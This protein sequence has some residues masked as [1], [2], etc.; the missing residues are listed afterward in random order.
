MRIITQQNIVDLQRY[1]T[2]AG[3][4]VAR[5]DHA[6]TGNPAKHKRVGLNINTTVPAGRVNKRID[7]IYMAAEK[8]HLTPYGLQRGL[9]QRHI[10]KTLIPQLHLNCTRKDI[11]FIQSDRLRTDID[12]LRRPKGTT[13]SDAVTAEGDRASASTKEAKTADGCCRQG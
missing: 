1:I 5:T 12:I 13:R 3:L 8:N 9:V 6:R 7:S 11:D 10:A 4:Q 2:A